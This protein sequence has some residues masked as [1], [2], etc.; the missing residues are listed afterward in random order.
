M[1]GSARQQHDASTPLEPMDLLVLDGHVDATLAQNCT[2][3]LIYLQYLYNTF[4]LKSYMR[5]EK[6]H[7]QPAQ[8][9]TKASSDG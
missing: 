2:V 7:L 6:E 5:M 4:Q 1:P 3:P 8:E 9:T